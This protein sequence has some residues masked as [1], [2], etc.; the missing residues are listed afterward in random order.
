MLTFIQ[1]EHHSR[2]AGTLPPADHFGS[3]VPTPL[4]EYP[5]GYLPHVPNGWHAL[6][7]NIFHPVNSC[8]YAPSP[9][10]SA[11]KTWRVNLIS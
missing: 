10:R 7:C 6:N 5:T 1:N 8:L 11:Y 2:C 9:S 3:L 4:S